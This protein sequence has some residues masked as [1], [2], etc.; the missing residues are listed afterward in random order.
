MFYAVTAWSVHMNWKMGDNPDP[1]TW[2]DASGAQLVPRQRFFKFQFSRSGECLEWQVPVPL[3][4]LLS[5]VIID[6]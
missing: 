3:V 5:S 1:I 6:V 4:L 2:F